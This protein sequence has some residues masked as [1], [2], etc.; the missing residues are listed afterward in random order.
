MARMAVL[1]RLVEDNDLAR[2][3]R[4]RRIGPMTPMPAFV[5]AARPL[6]TDVIKRKPQII[7]GLHGAASATEPIGRSAV[8]C[9]Q[10]EE[11]SLM[12]RG[13]FDVDLEQQVADL[14]KELSALKRTLARRSADFYG[15]AGD[16]V[17]NY[18]SDIAGR[19]TPTFGGLRRQ[20]RS[21]QRVAYDHPAVVAT[22]GLVVIGLVASLVL[23]PRPSRNL[24][25]AARR[26]AEAK[27]SEETAPANRRRGRNQHTTAH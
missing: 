1:L 18:L 14:G 13:V 20:T 17:S 4:R 8:A 26:A 11:V 9:H 21:V 6:V 7:R 19:V 12:A 27:R 15:D 10:L 16:T 25:R 2:K 23:R 3:L 5:S 22:V 24:V